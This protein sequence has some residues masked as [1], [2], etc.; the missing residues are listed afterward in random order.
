M[1]LS[2]NNF[3]AGGFLH[4]DDIHTVVTSSESVEEQVSMVN[5][6]AKENFTSIN[7][8]LSL[9]LTLTSLA[10]TP[11]VKLMV[12]SFQYVLRPSVLDIGGRAIYL[13]LILSRR[14]SERLGAPSSSSRTHSL[15]DLQ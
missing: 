5:T 12:Q 14:I 3:Y 4:A 15:L 7:V 13:P 6:F 10:N 1:G 8:T 9:F 2:I 11:T